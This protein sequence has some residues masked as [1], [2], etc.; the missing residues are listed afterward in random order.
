MTINR[1]TLLRGSLTCGA[2]VAAASAGLLTPR[3]VL[4][5]WPE[6]AFRAN[7]VNDAMSGIEA[8]GAV[9]SSEITIKAPDIAENGAV[10]PISVSTSLSG[11]TAIAILAAKNNIPLASDFEFGPG[12]EGFVSTRIKMA[13][14]SDV[15]AV[16]K[17]DSGVYTTSKEVK[18]TIGGCGG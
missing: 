7:D 2:A 11:V 9:E 4:A 6:M 17:T 10:V 8:S 1:R 3:V 13:E 18:V 15:I 12:V 16:V 5:A 14:T